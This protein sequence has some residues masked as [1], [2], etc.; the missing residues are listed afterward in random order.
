MEFGKVGKPVRQAWQHF[1]QMHGDRDVP[2]QHLTFFGDYLI[3][4]GLTV[5]VTKAR[6]VE[7]Y[8]VGKSMT[9]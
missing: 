9:D 1:I 4:Q 2:Q 5:D 8:V 3:R 6:T 7:L